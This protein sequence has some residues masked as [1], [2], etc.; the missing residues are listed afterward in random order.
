MCLVTTQTTQN[1]YNVDKQPCTPTP[2]N[3]VCNIIMITFVRGGQSGLILCTTHAMSE[4]YV[5]RNRLMK[6]GEFRI[7]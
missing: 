2:C 7:Y 5:D 6:N 1:S 4:Q 3:I